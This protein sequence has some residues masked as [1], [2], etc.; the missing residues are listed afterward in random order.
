MRA[1]NAQSRLRRANK[2][3]GRRILQASCSKKPLLISRLAA[4]VTGQREVA[5]ETATKK[6]QA[7][8]VDQ[9]VNAGAPTLYTWTMALTDLVNLWKRVRLHALSCNSVIW[10]FRS[11]LIKNLLGNELKSKPSV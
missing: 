10:L 1:S 7:N 5:I 4:E 3:G 8:S 11:V 6:I 2:E 9:G